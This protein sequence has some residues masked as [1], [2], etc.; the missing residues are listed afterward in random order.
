MDVGKL[1]HVELQEPS[2]ITLTPEAC[3]R[4]AERFGLTG[5]SGDSDAFN[6]E[7]RQGRHALLGSLRARAC[8]ALTPSPRLRARQSSLNHVEQQVYKSDSTRLLDAIK[9]WRWATLR[10]SPA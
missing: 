8:I 7:C 2:R 4:R 9:A 10:V 5:Q 1:R 3:A 6:Q